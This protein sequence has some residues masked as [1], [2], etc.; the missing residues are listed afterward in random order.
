MISMAS[1]TSTLSYGAM[2]AER[3]TCRPQ[4]ELAQRTNDAA[5]S[6]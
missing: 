1:I 2:H 3:V 6:G 5:L 4:S